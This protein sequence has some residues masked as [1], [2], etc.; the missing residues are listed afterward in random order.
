MPGWHTFNLLFRCSPELRTKC[1]PIGPTVQLTYP[2]VW[3]FWSSLDGRPFGYRIPYCHSDI[4][5][6]LYSDPMGQ[7]IQFDS[8][9]AQHT[10]RWSI[11]KR[12]LHEHWRH[13][14]FVHI[15]A[16][17]CTFACI[18]VQKTATN[19]CTLVLTMVLSTKNCAQISAPNVSVNPAKYVNQCNYSI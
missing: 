3:L 5:P 4:G 2:L 10:D 6:V 15:R 17:F 9:Q 11:L 12:D 8:E 13:C 18:T 1:H 16:I 14:W 7:L 19:E